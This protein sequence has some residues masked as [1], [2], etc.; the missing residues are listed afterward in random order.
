MIL[1]FVTLAQSETPTTSG[2]NTAVI[3]VAVVGAISAIVGTYLSQRGNKKQNEAKEHPQDASMLAERAQMAAEREQI[4]KSWASLREYEAIQFQAAREEVKSLHAV[5]Q[6]KDK[7]IKNKDQ[8]I[9]E[10]RDF[11]LRGSGRRK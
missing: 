4:S 5:I 7:E 2:N 11:I 3:V 6:E 9:R 10:L 8:I 1:A